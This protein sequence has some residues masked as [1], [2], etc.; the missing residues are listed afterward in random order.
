MV[1]DHLVVKNQVSRARQSWWHRSLFAR[2][3]RAVGPSRAFPLA[4]SYLPMRS[5]IPSTAR[6][7]KLKTLS[8]KLANGNWLQNYVAVTGAKGMG[9]TCLI[10]TALTSRTGKVRVDL[11]A[12]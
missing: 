6:M 4:L 11:E 1:T 10:E 7:A 2:P 12:S 8:A 3:L 5:D 9:N